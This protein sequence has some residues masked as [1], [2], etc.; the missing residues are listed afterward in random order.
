MES[1]QDNTCDVYLNQTPLATVFSTSDS[2][3][4]I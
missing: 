2:L 4:E 1:G 3:F